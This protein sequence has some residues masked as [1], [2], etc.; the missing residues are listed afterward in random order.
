MVVLLDMTLEL[1]KCCA[2]VNHD[3]FFIDVVVCCWLALLCFD[4]VLCVDSGGR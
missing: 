4:L 1:L 2:F 3:V